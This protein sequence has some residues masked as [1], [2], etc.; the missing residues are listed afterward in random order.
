MPPLI[1]SSILSSP[2]VY[3]RRSFQTPPFFFA[4]RNEERKKG[5]ERERIKL[6]DFVGTSSLSPNGRERRLFSCWM[7]RGTVCQN[8]LRVSNH[9]EAARLEISW[10][11]FPARERYILRLCSNIHLIIKSVRENLT[12]IVIAFSSSF[13]TFS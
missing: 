6:F 9:E 12:W 11:K 4:W 2:S 3:I 10:N 8:I 13:K 5:R 1:P 7:M